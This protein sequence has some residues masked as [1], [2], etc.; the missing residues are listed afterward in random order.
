MRMSKGD[1]TAPTDLSPKGA[2]EY[3]ERIKRAKEGHVPVGGAPMPKM[4]RLD[5]DPPGAPRDRN[6]GVQQAHEQQAAAQ[7]GM[8]SAMTPEEYQ[9]AV[10]SGQAMPGVGGAYYR[11]QPAGMKVPPAE[12]DTPPRPMKLEGEGENP[13]NPP[14]PEGGLSKETLGQL[15]GMAQAKK[16]EEGKE[17]EQK[18]E[19]DDF[20]FSELGRVTQD[21]LSNKK[22]REAIEAKITDELNYEDLI[23]Q[24][25]LRQEVPILPKFRP[26]FRTP[27]GEEDLFIKRL[28]S[29]QE[30][31]ERYIVDKFA[32]MGLTCGLYALNG[33]PF[34]SHLDKDGEPDEELFL[35]K[36]KAILKYPLVIVADMSA[37]FTWFTER[38]QTLLSVDKVRDF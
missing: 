36:M 19:D 9:R 21:I 37:N 35:A 11:N 30:G 25:E 15:E 12:G 2:G 24:Q 14:R 31:S 29:G 20:D 38:V 23:I 18:E 27:C 3:A 6:L 10:A 7:G 26:M 17:E 8:G 34:P 28:I 16:K 4:P 13:A 5:E 1:P 32:C 33:K 22:R